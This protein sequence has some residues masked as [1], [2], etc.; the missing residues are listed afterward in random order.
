MAYFWGFRNIK[1]SAHGETTLI[2]TV[3]LKQRLDR[4]SMSPTTR[5]KTWL[6]APTPK[7]D[8]KTPDVLRVQD[9]KVVKRSALPSST[10]K[11]LSNTKANITFWGNLLPVFFS[12]P[13][14]DGE[15]ELEGETLIDDGASNTTAEDVDDTLIEDSKSSKYHVTK[16]LIA[17][18]PSSS[19]LEHTNPALLTEEKKEHFFDIDAERAI[20]EDITQNITRRGSWTPDELFLFHKLNM[21]GF[22]AILPENWR[23]DFPTMPTR[24]FGT[25]DQDVFISSLSG[26]DFRG[27]SPVFNPQY[28]D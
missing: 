24:L 2:S 9:S 10:K 27:T 22:E 1:S 5:T 12:K 7:K 21:R 3:D 11:S 26:K 17:T 19:E 6:A 18:I 14:Q 16:K 20:R 15:D 23:L 25:A 13:K 28:I 4:R 8:V